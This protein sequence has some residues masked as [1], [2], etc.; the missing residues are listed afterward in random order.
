MA[1]TGTPSSA[2]YE[3]ITPLSGCGVVRCTSCTS[4]RLVRARVRVRLGLRLRVRVRL[5]LRLTRRVRVRVR[6]RLRVRIR[7]AARASVPATWP[8]GPWGAGRRRS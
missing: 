7:A 8:R 2:E 5:R 6:V 3:A 4:S 1:A